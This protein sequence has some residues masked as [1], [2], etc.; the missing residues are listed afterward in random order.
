MFE[1]CLGVQILIA[2]SEVVRRK[3]NLPRRYSMGVEFITVGSHKI[4]LSHGRDRLQ[5]LW[6]LRSTYTQTLYTGGDGT[7]GDYYQLMS[8]GPGYHN[9]SDKF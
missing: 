9:F 7:G 6:F 3:K 4:D 1:G 2:I 8:L 5:N